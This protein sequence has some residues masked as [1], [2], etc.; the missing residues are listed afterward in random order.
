MAEAADEE[1]TRAAECLENETSDSAR[2]KQTAATEV[3][4][5]Q[6]K[7]VDNSS[8]FTE[9][10][11]SLN[12]K[13]TDKQKDFNDYNTEGSSTSN[14]YIQ[15]SSESNE[16]Y[17]TPSEEINTNPITPPYCNQP[18]SK[19]SLPSPPHL[20]IPPTIIGDNNDV[21]VQ[22]NENSKIVTKDDDNDEHDSE[23]ASSVGR[24]D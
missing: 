12:V 23:R 5:W 21:I 1:A 20:H 18:L 11:D 9:V 14:R 22:N 6:K 24:R 13:Y 16:V 10:S 2:I 19:K 15:S 17:M 8:L 4:S 7:T 3:Y